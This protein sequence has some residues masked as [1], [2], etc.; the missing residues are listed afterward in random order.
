MAILP[1]EQPLKPRARITLF[2]LRADVVARKRASLSPPMRVLII[3][4][5]ALLRQSVSAWLH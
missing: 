2:S 5:S 3:E 1:V 4:D